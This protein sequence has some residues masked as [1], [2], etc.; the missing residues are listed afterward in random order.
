MGGLLS[1]EV[2]F[3]VS[4]DGLGILSEDVEVLSVILEDVEVLSVAAED[5]LVVGK[6][7]FSY[8][9]LSARVGLAGL[10]RV[11]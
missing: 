5:G 11:G 3:V 2:S 1:D 9:I 4:E 7:N 10:A 6:K 8:L